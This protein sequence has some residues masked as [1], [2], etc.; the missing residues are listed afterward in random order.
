MALV[1][2]VDSLK[3]EGKPNKRPNDAENLYYAEHL[4]RPKYAGRPVRGHQT[5]VSLKAPRSARSV[6]SGGVH[7]RA[8]DDLD[9]RRV[10]EEADNVEVVRDSAV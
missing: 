5:C 8:E 10:I 9:R 1:R 7:R 4:E 3:S 6:V 2:T